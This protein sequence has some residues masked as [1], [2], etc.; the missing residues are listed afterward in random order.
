MAFTL[1]ICALSDEYI[2]AI[3]D[4]SLHVNPP[5]MGLYRRLLYSG[6]LGTA[7]AR[8]SNKL[9]EKSKE[10]YVAFVNIVRVTVGNELSFIIIKQAE[11]LPLLLYSSTESM[12]LFLFCENV[13]KRFEKKQKFLSVAYGKLSS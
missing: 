2:F 8:S 7:V 6:A 5:R 11:Y 13:Q 1:C 4:P 10:L 3:S 12:K 9:S